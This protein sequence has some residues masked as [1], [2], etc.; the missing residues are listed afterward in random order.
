MSQVIKG[1]I[2]KIN[3]KTGRG[4]RGVWNLYSAKME[5]EDGTEFDKWVSFGFDKPAVKEG[6]YVKLTVEENEQGYLNVT[7]VKALKNAPARKGA[8]KGGQAAASGAGAN[9]GSAATTQ[10]SIH[11]QSARKD[12][13]EA[14]NL[15]LVQDALPLSVA[16]TAAGKAKRYEEILALID[17]LTVQFFFDAETHRLLKTVADAGA[18]VADAGSLP[19]DDADDNDDEAEESDESDDEDGESDDE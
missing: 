11:Y 6:D 19:E 17:K 1:F 18:T 5:L 9:V 12:A 10:Q 14:L 3:M 7:E 2:A 16:K 15:L 8:A 4:K 13:L